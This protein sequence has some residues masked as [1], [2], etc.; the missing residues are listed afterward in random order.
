MIASGRVYIS[1]IAVI[2]LIVPIRLNSENATNINAIFVV[3]NDNFPSCI[4]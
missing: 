2:I 3:N 1:I 4:L